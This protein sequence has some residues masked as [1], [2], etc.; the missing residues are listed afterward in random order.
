MSAT[1]NNLLVKRKGG[2]NARK[3]AFILSIIIPTVILSLVWTLFPIIWSMILMFYNYNPGRVGGPFLGLG[4]TNPFIGLEN[5]QNMIIGTSLEASLFRISLRN[6]LFFSITTLPFN[7]II[8]LPLAT[9]IE[10]MTSRLK[11]I[12]RTIYF[13]PAVTSSVGVALIWK[14]IYDPQSGMLNQIIHFF[15]G[16]PVAWLTD[17]KAMFLGVS[18]GMWA[19]IVTRI[20]QDFPYNMVI[21]IAG[22]QGIPKEFKEAAMIDGA[23]P[24]QA[25]RYVT[26][27]LLQPILAFVCVMT[28]LS[29]FQVFDLIQ[30]MTNGGPNNQTRVLMLDI[31]EGAFRYLQMGW[32]SS[33]ALVMVI[34][35]MIITLIQMRLLRTKWEY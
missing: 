11:I 24:V 25:F 33:V 5:F 18:V 13:L 1:T 28:M 16:T 2:I 21:F 29:S 26:I 31:Y 4:G 22:L 34:I 27:P 14:Y 3:R 32:A 15:H 7:L 8:T 10:A 30:V 9:L 20:W 19:L 35:V 12:Y 17:P 23:S 6:T